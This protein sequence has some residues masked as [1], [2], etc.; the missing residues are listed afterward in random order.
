[1]EGYDT[2]SIEQMNAVETYKKQG[3][4]LR[5][6]AQNSLALASQMSEYQIED[7]QTL[8]DI[9]AHVQ[10]ADGAM[11]IAQAQAELL[12]QL[13]TQLQKLQTLIQAQ[14]QMQ[15]TQIAAEADTVERQRTAQE[16]VMTQPLNVNPEDGEDW[17]E[18]WHQPP[19]EW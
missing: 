5:D 13:S 19:M 3:D 8:D 15:A 6:T 2:Q 4:A 17:S 12:A 14:I 10:G 18:S 7:N 1:M 16:K 11:E 9:Q